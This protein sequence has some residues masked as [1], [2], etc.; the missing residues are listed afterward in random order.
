MYL[1]P[2]PDDVYEIR[3]LYKSKIPSLASNGTT[4]LMTTYPHVYLY[5]T[6]CEAAPYI[7]DDNR[8]AIWEKKYKESIES[9]NAQDWYSGS[10]MRVRTDVRP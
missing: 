1:A 3:L 6:L 5:A 8:T 10:T 7:K 2:V 4:W 9:V